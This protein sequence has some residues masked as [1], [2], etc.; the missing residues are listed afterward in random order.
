MPTLAVHVD[1]PEEQLARIEQAAGSLRVLRKS[2]ITELDEVEIL[3]AQRLAP[4]RI[5]KASA[6]RWV[7]TYGAGVE[8]L[9]VPEVIA[10]HD[11]VITNARIHAQPI[12]EH[13]FGWLLSYVRNLHKADRQ[14]RQQKWDPE[15]LREGLGTLEGKTLGVLG[16]G[17]IG[18]RIAELGAAF[19]MR[20][21]AY[22]RNWQDVPAPVETAYG[23]LPEFL[24]ASDFV[25]NTLPATTATQHL[26]G[27][28]EFEAMRPHAFLVNIGR[29]STIDTVALV[30]ALNK[31][32]LGGAA[33]D[34]TDPEPLPP[35]H[36]LWK[37]DNVLI[38]PHYAGAHPGYDERATELFV[39]NLAR[40]LAGEPL[41]NVVNAEAGY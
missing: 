30:D 23:E 8:W 29:G 5:A 32:K 12:A 13:V 6:L 27:A 19:G 22:R 14:A 21:I 4:Q 36:S 20:V 31:G 35:T 25:V 40:Y 24:A 3:F 34:V 10:R 17:V 37:F 1:L 38:T 18:L 15:A 39:A 28:R 7:Q 2:E 16:L 9:L 26:L 11:L 41:A 33:L